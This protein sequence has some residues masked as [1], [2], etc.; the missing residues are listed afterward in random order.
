[1]SAPLFEIVLARLYIDVEFRTL[2]LADP[3]KALAEY[4][5]APEEVQNLKAID[6]AGLLMASQNFIR[7]QTRSHGGPHREGQPDSKA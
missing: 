1:M 7:L 5:L 6:K 3:D 4:D 2:F